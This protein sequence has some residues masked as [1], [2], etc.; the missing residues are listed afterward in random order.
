MP[1]VTAP[2]RF[3]RAP[4]SPDPLLAEIQA[5]LGPA[6]AFFR[7]RRT[8]AGVVARRLLGRPATDDDELADHL[9]RER[10]R[11]SRMDGSIDGSLVDTARAAW[12][13]LDLG[14]PADH[15]AVVRMVGFLLG[16][17]DAPGRWGEEE[18]TGDGFFSPGPIEHPIA[19]LALA[20]GVLFP[21]ES[22]ARFAASCIALRTT[23]RAGMDDRARVRE[24]VEA[25]L[26]ME[27]LGA[28]LL[29]LVLGTVGLASP[30][31]R[32]AVANL[33]KTVLD[34][35]R[36]DGEWDGVPLFHALEALSTIPTPEARAG[37]RNA[38]RAV[39]A[40]QRPSGAFDESE[41]EELALVA[42]RALVTARATLR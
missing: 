22:D 8:P 39:L 1:D 34:R 42:A 25:L 33:T 13:L 16:R 17:Q 20:T 41:Q 29:F 28:P 37:I 11:K 19:P 9:I 36:E 7:E 2:T 27:D 21:D 32:D 24:H 6:L 23:L 30:D 15:A 14:A 5:A 4:A 26:A 40:R 12:E 3:A 35:Q 10:R 18:G 31:Y 38:A